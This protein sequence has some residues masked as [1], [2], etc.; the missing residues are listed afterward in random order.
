MKI[1]ALHHDIGFIQTHT[2]QV[3]A[4]YAIARKEL[5]EFKSSETHIDKICGIIIATKIPQ[6][7]KTHLEAI[8]ADADLEYLGT[9][10]FTKGSELIYE[11]LKHPNTKMHRNQWNDIQHDFMN[12]HYEKN[13]QNTFHAL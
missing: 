12:K 1:S 2:E 7:P 8:L 5:L 10:H 4:E 6:E 3:K 13:K 11:E 9:K